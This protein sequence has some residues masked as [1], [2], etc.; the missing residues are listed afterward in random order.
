MPIGITM[1]WFIEALRANP[2]LALF[3]TIS[4]GYLVGRLRL[5][6]FS[7]GPVIGALVAGVIV[8]QLSIPV[9]PSLKNALFLLFLFAIGYRTGPLFFRG[10]K[11]TAAPQ[12]ALTLLLCLTGLVTSLGFARVLGL[13]AGGASGLVA[14]AMT[15]AAALGTAADAIGR[16]A[17][18]ERTREALLI[19]RTVAFAV[20][21]LIGMVV[22]VWFL[23]RVGPR[24][25]GADLA[26]E[27]RRL[28]EEM[29]VTRAEAGVT[30]AYTEFVTR[31]Y[32][33][34]PD[35]AGLTVAGV[36]HLFPGVRVFVTRLRRAGQLVDDVPPGLLLTAGDRIALAGR[37]EAL[38]GE[39]NPLHEH[40]V[41]DR[42]L[43]DIPTVTLNVVLT[44]A[45]LAARPIIGLATELDARGVFLRRLRRAG[46]ELPFTPA[47]IVQRGDLLEVSGPRSVLAR[48]ADRIGYVEWPGSETDLMAVAAAIFLGGLA[49]LPAL[50]LG[51]FTLALSA[52]VGVLLAGLVFGW[53]RS[54]WP[55]FGRF[56]EPAVWI[57]ESFGLA[58]FLALVGI[59]A[60]PDFFR[61]LGAAGLPLVVAGFVTVLV[62][63]TVALL[64]GRYVFRLHPGILL[65]VCCGAGTSA[66]A[67]AAVEAVADSKIPA[68]GYGVGCAI[69]NILLALWGGVMVMLVGA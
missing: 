62:P 36:E 68:L 46:V 16:L 4:L 31:A 66:P 64:V 3:L 28:E 65:G 32:D 63:H 2:E 52:F 7:L 35:L 20:T 60:G 50:V 38:A 43:L 19:N 58:G 23:S 45:D 59:E 25:L 44:R 29:G 13:D 49:G 21:Y 10:L 15:S 53:L 42:E 37:M 18:D 33:L 1:D 14:G 54:V 67:L 30:S 56:P 69:G 41:R 6:S 48:L 22:V 40:E 57:F 61:G 55:R 9:P 27:C 34:P 47:T 11:A 24:L 12:I 8:G 17:V 26:A 5:G 39:A 51:R